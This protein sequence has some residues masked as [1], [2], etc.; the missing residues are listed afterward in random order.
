MKKREEAFQLE[1]ATEIAAHS[2]KIEEFSDEIRRLVTENEARRGQLAAKNME[3][4][5]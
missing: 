1:L 5:K 3:P 4:S 2:A